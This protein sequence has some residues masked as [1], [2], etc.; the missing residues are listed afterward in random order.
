MRLPKRTLFLVMCLGAA[1]T[2][3][4]ATTVAPYEDP[5]VEITGRVLGMEEF[6]KLAVA[7]DTVFETI[8]I[9]ELAIQYRKDLFLPPG[10]IV[11]AIRSDYEMLLLRDQSAPAVAVGLSKLF[12]YTGTLVSA[13]YVTVPDYEEK[14]SDFSREE[15]RLSEY[16]VVV[17]QPIAENAFGKVTRLSDHIIG[18]ENEVLRHQIVEAYEDYL[19]RVLT[20]YLDWY[21]AYENLKVAKSSYRENLKLLENIKRRQGS[22]IA[23]PIDVNKISLQ[24]ME[25]EEVLIE[26]SVRYRNALNF[27]RAAIRY[28]GEEG[29]VPHAPELYNDF[30]PDFKN[31]F[32][33]FRQAGRTFRILDLLESKSSLEV[34][35]DAHEL[36][37]SINLNVGFRSQWEGTE[38]A[39]EENLFFAGVSLEWPFPD[40]VERAE[41]ETSRIEEKKAALNTVNAHYRLFSDLRTLYQQMER[42]QRLLAIAEKKIELAQKVFEAEAENYSYGKV[43]LNDYIDAVNALDNSRFDRV[44]HRVQLKKLIIESLRLMDRLVSRQAIEEYNS[45]KE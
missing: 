45:G 10:D 39:K 3:A 14:G 28:D 9:D 2:A 25:R 5:E 23:L 40:E 38:L 42:E 22:S 24:V 4:V 32:A 15:D 31:D 26:S 8:L 18:L 30:T 20:A 6:M 44:F 17:S 36:L 11:L 29:L 27:I 33:L 35:R 43:T 34:D 7:K 21:E 41:L 16:Q 13:Q 37:P 12:P 19:A 1:V